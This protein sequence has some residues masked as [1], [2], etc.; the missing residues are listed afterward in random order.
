M[1]FK[2]IKINL[3]KQKTMFHKVLYF[4]FAG[5]VNGVNNCTDLCPSELCQFFLSLTNKS[6]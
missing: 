5:K 1:P 6:V 2:E 3:S 4:F